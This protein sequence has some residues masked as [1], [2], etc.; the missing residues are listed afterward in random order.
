MKM[1]LAKN[2]Y[3][4]TFYQAIVAIKISSLMRDATF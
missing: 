3:K 1:E 2:A 4:V